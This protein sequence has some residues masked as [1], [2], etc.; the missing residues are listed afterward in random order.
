MTYM[1][2]QW[3]GFCLELEIDTVINRRKP[4]TFAKSSAYYTFQGQYCGLQYLPVGL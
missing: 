3:Y 4:Q 2:V 1:V